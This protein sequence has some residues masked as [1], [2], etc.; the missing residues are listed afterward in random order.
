MLSTVKDLGSHEASCHDL[1][2]LMIDKKSSTSSV[3]ELVV[4]K[5]KHASAP[6]RSEMPPRPQS[7]K[8]SS[9][10]KS[11][12]MTVMVPSGTANLS[13]LAERS[14]AEQALLQPPVETGDSLGRHH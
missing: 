9:V 11:P 3:K 1:N 10:A 12:A 4:Q 13:K 5:L 8:G 2:Q 6:M 7:K 14:P